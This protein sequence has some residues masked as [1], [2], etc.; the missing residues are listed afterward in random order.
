MR[1]VIDLAARRLS[2]AATAYYLFD[3][4]VMEDGDFDELVKLVA[5]KWAYLPAYYQDCFESPEAL[6]ATAFHIYISA[7]CYNATLHELRDAGV[8]EDLNARPF[9]AEAEWESPIGRTVEIMSL[10][11]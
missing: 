4:P 6:R 8:D 2:V 1:Q 7:A 5:D 11:G 9:E 10:G 3:N